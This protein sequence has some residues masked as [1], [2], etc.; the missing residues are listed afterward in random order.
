MSIPSSVVG[1]GNSSSAQNVFKVTFSQALSAI[2]TLESW[3]DSTFTTTNREQFTGTTNNGNIPYVSAVATTDA[4][5]S[6][7]WQPASPAA[8]G[9]T[10]NRLKGLTN[11]VNLSAS[12]PGAGGAVRFNLAFQIASDTSVPSTNT[13]GV[14]AIRFSFSGA[15]P[16]LVW[17]FNDN[18]AGGTEGAPSF[19]N[20]TPGAAGNFIRGAD[21]GASAG[22][23]AMTKPASGTYNAPAVWV[24]NV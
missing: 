8:G 7:N 17:Q 22:N 18:S 23:V 15:T 13:F 10:A 6:S 19:T 12:I 1:A 21:A 3:D 20:I 5:P 11:F 16:S 24:T 9:A 14:L 2:P 4:P